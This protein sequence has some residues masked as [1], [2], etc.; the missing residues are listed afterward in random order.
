MSVEIFRRRQQQSIAWSGDAS[1]SAFVGHC[2]REEMDKEADLPCTVVF[3]FIRVLFT[4]SI[5]LSAY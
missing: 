4:V 1:L 5:I 3:F 2:K